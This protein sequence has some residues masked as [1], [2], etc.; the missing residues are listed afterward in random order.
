MNWREDGQPER[1]TQRLAHDHGELSQVLDQI[2]PALVAGEINRAHELLDLF[3]ARLAVH[4]RAEHLHLFP[5]ILNAL[6]G[7]GTVDDNRKPTLAQAESAIAELRSDHNFFMHEL[8]LAV[9]GLRDLPQTSNRQTAAAQTASVSAAVLA[10]TERLA[11]HNELEETQVYPWAEEL[12]SAP[13]QLK[14]AARINDEL[15]NMPA[16]F[17][18]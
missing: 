7:V 6:G 10:V 2:L 5:A 13:E 4:I 1:M 14:L 3:W 16:R 9:R 12:L 15:T 8:S 18:T 17:D 11:A